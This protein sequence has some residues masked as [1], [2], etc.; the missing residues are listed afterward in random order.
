MLK[1]A[2]VC[3]CGTFADGGATGVLV[4][5]VL[6]T[7]VDDAQTWSTLVSNVLS[8]RVDEEEAIRKAEA[9][10]EKAAQG[11][12][13]VLDWGTFMDEP[14]LL[15]A[16]LDKRLAQITSFTGIVTGGVCGRAGLIG[17]GGTTLAEAVDVIVVRVAAT[18]RAKGMYDL[19]YGADRVLEVDCIVFYAFCSL[20]GSLS[21]FFARRLRAKPQRSHRRLRSSP[22]IRCF[23]QPGP[24]RPPLSRCAPII[25]CWTVTLRLP[26][27]W[28]RRHRCQ[29]CCWTRRAMG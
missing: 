26:A 28:S 22:S 3:M 21:P 1:K 5:P 12:R 10:V 23:K 15:R 25:C 24:T 8:L 20:F 6:V 7:Q 27:R 13:V 29:M 16:P 17:A 9:A 11:V 14:A 4:V 2:H 18:V 19:R